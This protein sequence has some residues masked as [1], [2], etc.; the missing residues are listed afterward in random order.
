MTGIYVPLVS[1]DSGREGGREG[2]NL[3]VHEYDTDGGGM[4]DERSRGGEEDVECFL[5]VRGDC[6]DDVGEL[7][8]TAHDRLV[9]DIVLIHVVSRM[10]AEEE[11]GTYFDNED[12]DPV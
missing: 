8:L 1:E 9:Y 6:Y 3:D 5:T 12:M 7:E 2:T 10:R 4:G 11:G